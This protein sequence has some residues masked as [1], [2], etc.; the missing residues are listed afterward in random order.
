MTTVEA[1]IQLRDDIKK[2]VTINLNAIGKPKASDI[3]IDAIDGMDATT[4]QGALEELNSKTAGTVLWENQSPTDSFAEQTITLSSGDFDYFEIYAGVNNAGTLEQCFKFT[5]NYGTLMSLGSYGS[6]GTQ[7]ATL[8]RMVEYV[9]D[10]QY[11][12]SNGQ[13]TTGTGSMTSDNTVLIPWR[14]VGY[15]S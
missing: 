11:K 12:I 3:K 10:T 13:R 5:K 9:S 6:N 2:W 1:L 7:A 15:K 8:R 14:I 4:A